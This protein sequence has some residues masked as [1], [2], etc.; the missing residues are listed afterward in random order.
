MII[1]NG[2]AYRSNTLQFICAKLGIR[3]V[4]CP[5]YE[6]QG[7][8]KLERWHRTLR[9]QFL[10]E[11]KMTNLQTLDDVNSRLW[12]WLE[13][14]YHITPHE[15][16]D[17]ETPIQRWREDLIHVRPLGLYAKDIDDI[18]CHRIQRQVKKDGTISWN[19]QLVEVP[20]EC[21]GER[22]MLVVDP[23]E[24]KPLRVE[25]LSG[26]LLGKAHLLDKHHNCYRK[27]QRPKTIA[28]D[29]EPSKSNTSV[30]EI[31]QEHY[32]K[33]RIIPSNPSTKK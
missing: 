1:D 8:G 10:T 21:V 33:Q 15:G 16:I 22:I 9:D 31:A 20:Y 25:T 23:H 27:R 14:V 13:Q 5:A 2:S 30:V 3:L 32:E 18:F 24:Q 28:T 26:K 11:L 6:P 12:A 19:N 7:K 29:N 17:Q 4:Y